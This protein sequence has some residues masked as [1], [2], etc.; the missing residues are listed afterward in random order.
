MRTLLSFRSPLVRAA[1]FSDKQLVD[2]TIASGLM[3]AYNRMAISFRC[4]AHGAR[5]A[6]G[7]VARNGSG[8]P[9]SVSDL[10]CAARSVEVDKGGHF[11]AWEQP[12]LSSTELRAAFRSLQSV[13]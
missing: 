8:W 6:G 12:E 1:V 5:R 3:N 11:A 10:N 9:F 2:L 7:G 4:D 13:H